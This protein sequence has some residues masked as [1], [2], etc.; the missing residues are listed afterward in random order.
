MLNLKKLRKEKGFTQLF[1][2]EKFDLSQQSIY[3]YENNLAEPDIATLKELAEFF[4]TSVDYL[5][6]ASD[7]Q[8]P[9]TRQFMEDLSNLEIEYL[10]FFQKMGSEDRLLMFQ[11][12]KSLTAKNYHEKP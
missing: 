9:Y 3:K 7:I 12:S 5:V 1:L 4:N 6:G 2:A 10:H 8:D 11:L